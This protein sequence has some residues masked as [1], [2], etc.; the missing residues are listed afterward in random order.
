MTKKTDS[1]QP[2]NDAPPTADP[3]QLFSRLGAELFN[4]MIGVAE[5][6]GEW[7]TRAAERAVATTRHV[8]ALACESIE[9][10]GQL[11]A[12]LR[13]SAIENLRATAG[14]TTKA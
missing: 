1:S 11:S 9:Y 13:R 4:P 3:T 5:Q 6:L 10:W 7:E 12:E 14:A 2:H 8:A